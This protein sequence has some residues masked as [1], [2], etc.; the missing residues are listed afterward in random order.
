M[1]QISKMDHHPM[2]PLKTLQKN[3]E[4]K[5]KTT[6]VLR[7]H[8]LLSIERFERF[9]AFNCHWTSSVSGTPTGSAMTR[10]EEWALLGVFHIFSIVFLW[11][12]WLALF[13]LLC[14]PWFATGFPWCLCMHIVFILLILYIYIYMYMYICIQKYRR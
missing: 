12:F 8:P 11:N 13:Y 5:H 9:G 2:F 14:F 3:L 7:N 6:K 4:K 10:H 1:L